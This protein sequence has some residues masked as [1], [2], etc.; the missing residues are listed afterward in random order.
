MT[1]RQLRQKALMGLVTC[2]TVS[3]CL[4]GCGRQ[5][6]VQSPEALSLISQVYTACNT[7]N[8]KRIAICQ[9]ELDELI[10]VNKLSDVEQQAFRRILELARNGQWES[11]EKQALDFA[12][13]QVR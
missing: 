10:A 9:T 11:A 8:E 12:N 7:R 13:D 2:L 4:I 1:S 6:L 3:L 5:P